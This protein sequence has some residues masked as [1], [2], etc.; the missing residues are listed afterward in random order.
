[1]S[2]EPT[3]AHNNRWLL[4]HAANVTS[5][6][7]EDG[8]IAKILEVIG[9]PRGWC[10]EFGAW[11]GRYLSNTHNLIANKGFSAVMIEGSA[12]TVPRSARRRSRA[13]RELLALNAFVGFTADDGLDA[14]LSRTPIPE[15]FDV[16]SIDIDGNDYHVWNAVTRYRPRVVVIE[17]NPTIPTADRLRAARRYVDQPGREHHGAERLAEQKG[18]ELVRSRLTTACSCART[19]FAAFGIEDNSVASLRADESMVTYI[20]NGFDGTVFIRGYGELG[21][22][23][24]PYREKRMQ[25]DRAHVSAV[26]RYVRA[27]HESAREAL[28]LVEEA[29]LYLAGGALAPS[30]SRALSALTKMMS[31]W[32]SR[33]SLRVGL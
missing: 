14:I 6:N 22:H 5:Q 7:G 10:V 24:M 31:D 3:T 30:Y 15:D 17:Y 1:M 33:P 21:W 16:L 25:L 2:A 4:E 26:P 27:R 9:E 20:F 28:P 12:T 29:G 8:I 23:G 19:Y 13:T 11:D 18:Y 32:I